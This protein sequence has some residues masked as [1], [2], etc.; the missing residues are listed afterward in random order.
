M[1]EARA[2]LAAWWPLGASLVS[3]ALVVIAAPGVAPIPSASWLAWIAFVPLFLAIE[4][5]TPRRA[6]ALG[7]ATGFAVNAGVSAWFPAVIARFSGMSPPLAVLVS[8]AIWSW[9]GLLWAAWAGLTARLKHS[10]ALIPVSAGL[11]VVFERCMP[12]VF[13][14]SL[15]LTQYCNLWIA[16]AS[17]LGGPSVIAF[18]IVATGATIATSIRFLK[19]RAP[20][21]WAQISTAVALMVAANVFGALRVSS[22]R[23]QREAGA[24]S[25]VGVVQAGAVQTGWRAEPEPPDLLDRYQRASS[26]LER[27]R[28]PKDLLVWP[29][30]AYPHLLRRDS[31]H[32]Y[33]AGHARRIRRDFRAPLIFGHNA[34]D[35]SSRELSNAVSLL[36]SNDRLSVF[37]EKVVLI[38]YSEWLPAPIASRVKG[39]RYRPGT[40]FEPI[41]AAS[42]RLGAFICFES[43]FPSHVRALVKRQPQWLLNVSD[44]AWFGDSAEPEQHLATVVLRAIES[45]RDVLRAAGSGIS[46]HVS[47]TGEILRSTP[48]SRGSPEVLVAS[49]RMLEIRSLYSRMGDTFVWLCAAGVIVAFARTRARNRKGATT[50]GRR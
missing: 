16:Q 32:D 40:S 8:V 27:D 2:R 48:V 45:R 24:Q 33:P 5:V 1:S 3:A 36:D 42:S 50:A 4:H 20:L 39:V 14:Y 29:E 34:V 49:I 25:T 41:T 18:L 6:L 23:R 44:D 35:A 9:Q 28:G 31:A 38:P 17:E 46:A 11:F 21:P 19:A 26:T 10:R 7:W 12:L 43:A 15:G 30:K 47:A 13:P 37:Y 22:I